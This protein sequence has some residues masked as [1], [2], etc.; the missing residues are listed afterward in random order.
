[1]GPARATGDDGELDRWLAELR[2][3][4]IGHD[5]HRRRMLVQAAAEDAT[6]ASVITDL[7]ERG[8]PVV[9]EL[10]DDRLARGVVRLVGTD[11]VVLRD[12]R[13]DAIVHLGAV[14][15]IRLRPDRSSPNRSRRDV[16][17]ARSPGRP[18]EPV[19]FAG[20]VG[21]LV[22]SAPTVTVHRHGTRSPLT[23]ALV[24]MGDDVLVV[25]APP[26]ARVYVPLSSV[27][28]VSVTGSG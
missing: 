8:E 22:D 14:L 24:S 21:G 16:A 10:P 19:T 9:V 1:M 25:H 13:T 3:D 23:G 5:R 4:A 12:G 7:A 27:T 6:V 2:T 20:A 26:G 17:G 18:G 11:V 15:S 28:D